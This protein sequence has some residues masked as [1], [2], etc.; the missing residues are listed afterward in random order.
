M[1]DDAAK[2]LGY[3]FKDDQILSESLT[4]ASYTAHRLQS[5]E[6]MEFLG[7][8]ILGYVTCEYLF[9]TYPDLLEGEL[10]KIKSAVVSRRVCA[11]ISEKLGLGQ[12]L[13]MGKGMIGREALPQSILA[14]VFE[15]V[16][17]AIYLDGGF[18]PARAF[19]IEH[20]KPYIEEASEST[21]QQNFKSA[22]QQHA[23]KYLPGKP[24]YLVL[25]E[26]GP[27]HSKCFEVCVELD[28]QRFEPAWAKSKKEAEQA[29]ALAAL[30][31][32][33]LIEDTE[34]NQIHLKLFNG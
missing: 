13:R 24:C 2:L 25:D 20:T 4:H 17:A 12:F 34:D 23:Q 18:E 15:S 28:G 30:R 32:L 14:G 11:L 5:N 29:A 19:I 26:K 27:D 16:I 22:L 3:T 31:Q 7:D 6:R 1:L 9:Q 33:G 8:A 10:T 21:H